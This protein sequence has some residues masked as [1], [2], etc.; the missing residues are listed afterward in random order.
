MLQQQQV[1]LF[2]VTLSLNAACYIAYYSFSA[3]ILE[4]QSYRNYTRLTPRYPL[5]ATL[6]SPIC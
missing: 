1:L 3:G 2:A 5:Y 6:L 4:Q